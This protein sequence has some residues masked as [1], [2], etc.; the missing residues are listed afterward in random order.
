M[1]LVRLVFGGKSFDRQI[2]KA[3]ELNRSSQK[4][5]VPSQILLSVIQHKYC[6]ETLAYL[7]CHESTSQNFL[8]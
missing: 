7:T 4:M 8:L 1:S 3:R 5:L 2:I 6:L